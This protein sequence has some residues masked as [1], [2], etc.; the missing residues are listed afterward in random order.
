MW[1]LPL[2]LHVNKKCDDD[3]DDE[4]IPIYL[5]ICLSVFLRPSVYVRRYL[6]VH[7]SVWGIQTFSEVELTFAI[8]HGRGKIVHMCICLDQTA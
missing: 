7:Q 1:M 8:S 5:S 6:P 3:D 2:Y 4:G